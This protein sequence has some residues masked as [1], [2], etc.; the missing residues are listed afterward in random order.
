VFLFKRV[1]RKKKTAE[2]CKNTQQAKERCFVRL[3][4]DFKVIARD[5]L[6]AGFFCLHSKLKVFDD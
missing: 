6:F 4:V 2:M 1:T 3:F 5:V